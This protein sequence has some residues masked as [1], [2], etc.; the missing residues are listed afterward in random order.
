[1]NSNTA[2]NFSSDVWKKLL[3]ANDRNKVRWVVLG[4]SH[5][6]ATFI[7]QCWVCLSSHLTQISRSGERVEIPELK[8][9]EV[10]QVRILAVLYWVRRMEESLM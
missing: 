8:V 9:E 7:G 6:G 3:I 2:N 5:D 4:L 10:V 1:M